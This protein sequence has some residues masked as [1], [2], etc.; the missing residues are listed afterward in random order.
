MD[1]L[2]EPTLFNPYTQLLFAL[3]ASCEWRLP[4]QAYW[5]RISVTF[6]HLSCHLINVC[7]KRSGYR[8]T[9]TMQWGGEIVSFESFLI[10]PRHIAPY[11][12][13]N[14]FILNTPRLIEFPTVDQKFLFKSGLV[15]I[16]Q[17]AE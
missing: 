11:V 2:P 3:A 7:E 15:R 14:Q 17:L 16:R 10:G 4:T 8:H 9:L 13:V 1:S 12:A 6:N 5:V